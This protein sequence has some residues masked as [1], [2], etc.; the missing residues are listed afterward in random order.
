[1]SRKRSNEIIRYELDVIRTYDIE[2]AVRCRINSFDPMLD[3]KEIGYV[4]L[5]PDRTQDLGAY[6][7]WLVEVYKPC[8]KIEDCLIFRKDSFE[9]VE[10]LK[11]RQ[12]FILGRILVLR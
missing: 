7:N 10:E 11:K 5:D 4:D 2:K 8:K 1:M 9:K 3:V 6:I 12:G